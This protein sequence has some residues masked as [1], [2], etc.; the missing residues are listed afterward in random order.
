M[1][2][3]FKVPDF[4]EITMDKSKEVRTLGPR[5]WTPRPSFLKLLMSQIPQNWYNS[6][7]K[8]PLHLSKTTRDA[9]FGVE[10][11]GLLSMYPCP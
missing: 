1:K 2:C 9:K 5:S 11:Y 8:W 10:D 3:K 7:L 4:E 6:I